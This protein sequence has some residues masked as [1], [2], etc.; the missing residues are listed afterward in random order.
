MG[1]LSGFK[2]VEIAGI[3]PGQLCGMLLAEM[4]AEIIRID[5]LT[6]ADLGVSLPTKFN[7]MNRSRPVVA[8]DLHRKEG[9]ELVLQMCES[10]DALF[11]GF[12]PGVMERLGL[13]PSDCM[14]RNGKLV[15]GRI[16]GWGQTGPLADSVGH[17]GNYLAIAGALGSIGEKGGLPVMPLNFVADFGG[18]AMYLVAGLLAA[19]LEA[20]KSGKGQVVDAAMV[21]GVASMMTLFHGL[22]AGGLW[23]D[24]R[25]SNLLDGAA[26]FYRTYGTKDGRSIV[27]CAI[28]Q[29]FYR[30]LLEALDTDQIDAA[31]QFNTQKWPEH[32]A[33]F[34]K[35][36][37]Q[38]T[39]DECCELFDGTDSCV[40]PV[41]T[42]SEAQAHPQN[43]SRSTYVDIA[44]IS[45]PGPAPR[46]SRT[47]SEIAGPPEEPGQRTIEVLS[48]WGLPESQ[49]SELINAGIVGG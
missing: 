30:A 12:R 39:R 10:A 16:T 44:G 18:G 9:V 47:Q 13:G 22:R 23:Q 35:L 7:L 6:D 49:I 21:D 15:Y 4:G 2:I 40:T 20:S 1:P 3:G 36:F 26:P 41:L 25:G 42:M 5:R 33:H 43:E 29:R 17:D 45:Q 48:D 27:V 24:A 46:F 8:V 11:E 28:E 19:M 34:E 38:K 32:I 31:D 14:A 37:A